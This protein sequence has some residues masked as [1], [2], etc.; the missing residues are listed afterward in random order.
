MKSQSRLNLLSSLLAILLA[1]LLAS[2]CAPTPTPTP[3][4]PPKAATAT[5]P[6]V[7]GNTPVIPTSTPLPIITATPSPIPPCTDGLAFVEDVT[8]PDGTV[9][10][11]GENVDKRWLVQN[12]GS[13][14]WDSSYRLKHVGGAEMGATIEQALYPA[15]AGAQATIR[16][17]FTAPNEPGT[18][19]TAW[20][21]YNPDGI[22]FGDAVFMEIVVRP[23]AEITIEVVE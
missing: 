16:I 10:S 8:V 20:Q 3:F 22:A 17:S 1:I 23:A 4:V 6:L 14:N 5:Q 9:V 15:R 21:A 13:C 12:N 2:A 7:Q 18:H 11:S 19:T